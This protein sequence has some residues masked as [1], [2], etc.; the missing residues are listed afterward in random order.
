MTIHKSKGLEFDHVILPGLSKSPKS[1][2]T[3]LLRWQEQADEHNNSSLLLAA[4]GPYDE[5]NDPIYNYLKHEQLSR[6]I[7]EN[8]RVLYVAATRAIRQLHLSESK[9]DKR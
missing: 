3:P 4:L 6:S 8:T 9:C 5:D 2:E 7:V 1:N